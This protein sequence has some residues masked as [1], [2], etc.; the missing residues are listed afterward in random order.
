LRNYDN[1]L[2]GIETCIAATIQL[3]AL[4]PMNTI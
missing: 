1:L 2:S 4:D 3:K